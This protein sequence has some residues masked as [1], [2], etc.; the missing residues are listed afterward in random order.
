M[1]SL[2]QILSQFYL[3]HIIT[4]YFFTTEFYSNV[5]FLKSK[6]MS[7]SLK[8]SLSLIFFSDFSF[9]ICLLHVPPIKYFYPTSRVFL[10]C[11][12]TTPYIY[13]CRSAKSVGPYQAARWQKEPKQLYSHSAPTVSYKMFLY[14]QEK[15]SSAHCCMSL[16]RCTET[17]RIQITLQTLYTYS[18]LQNV[19]V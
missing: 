14:S 16:L 18:K 4:S 11:N 17:A 19:P 3:L 9:Y 8:S 10:L 13:L 12:T 7:R 15:N 2:I 6:S 1:L 5:T